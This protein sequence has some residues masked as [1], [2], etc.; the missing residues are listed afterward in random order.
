MSCSYGQTTWLQETNETKT[1]LYGLSDIKYVRRPFKLK[2]TEATIDDG[3]SI[4]GALCK[5]DEGRH[6]SNEL[7][8][9]LTATELGV[10]NGGQ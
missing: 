4:I 1:E 9:G 3:V 10:P 5:V 7:L 2:K 8:D 6:I